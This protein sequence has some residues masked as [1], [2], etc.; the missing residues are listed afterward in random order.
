[1]LY[2]LDG[3]PPATPFPD[4]GNAETE[5]NGLLAVGGDLSPRRLLQAYRAGVFPW[6]SDDQPILWWS[7][8]PRMVLFPGRLRISRSLRKTLRKQHYQVSVDQAFDQVIHACA[9]PR[10]D[11]SGTWLVPEMI[12]AYRKLHRLGVAHS[13]ETWKDG[14]LVGGLYGVSLGRVFFGESMFSRADDASK[15]ALVQLA[16]LTRAAEFTLID[17]QVYTGHLERLGAEEIPRS[18]FQQLLRQALTET[19][20]IGWRRA[21]H[22]AADLEANA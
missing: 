20:L 7:P 14:Q 3:S 11:D 13:V 21:P 19:P 2:L 10:R 1:M 5:P 4:P 22:P 16:E 15:V 18:R 9:G 8:D 12:S 17:C 6:F